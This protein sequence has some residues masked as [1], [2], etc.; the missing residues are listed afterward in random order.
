MRLVIIE[1][2]A[3]P[4][5]NDTQHD[6]APKAQL[7][8]H[9]SSKSTNHQLS[10]NAKKPVPVTWQYQGDINSEDAEDNEEEADDIEEKHFEQ[11]D[12]E[13]SGAQVPIIREP[14]HSAIETGSPI[15]HTN[16]LL[17]L[18][19]RSKKSMSTDLFEH[20]IADHHWWFT[21]S[22]MKQSLKYQ[23]KSIACVASKKLSHCDTVFLREQTKLAR[24]GDIAYQ[25][26]Q[27]HISH[28]P[29][30]KQKSVETVNQL[31]ANA[32]PKFQCHNE[33]Q[34]ALMYVAA[35][36]NI[37]VDGMEDVHQRLKQDLEFHAKLGNVVL[38]HLA[39][40]Q[41]PMKV[42]T[43]AQIAVYLL[44]TGV[45]CEQHVISLF[46]NDG[47]YIFPGEWN[48]ASKWVPNMSDYYL[49]PAILEMIKE[50]FFQLPLSIGHEVVMKHNKKI[51]RVDELKLPIAMVALGA[52]AVYATLL[53]WKDGIKMMWPF[54]GSI[55]ATT[56]QDHMETLE[57][58]K[59]EYP[60]V[61]HVIMHMLYNKV[62]DQP[63]TVPK[64]GVNHFHITDLTKYATMQ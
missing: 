59:G 64:K 51:N 33:Y 26:A 6:A 8:T 13:L 2:D 17:I 20:S 46:D 58:L 16:C 14:P 4:E 63:V 27:A 44:G 50:S 52:T 19:K 56:Y 38:D 62:N 15:M 61:F 11:T 45:K 55:F 54:N 37:G 31:M 41:S 22:L 1:S 36:C 49:N 48:T 12:S 57:A 42:N 39:M 18:M 7:Q 35:E 9:S 34:Q 28:S 32:C 60:N 43:T 5:D 10:R 53:E 29:Y 23:S 3:E 47:A 25:L 21:Q 40:A 24:L 30:R